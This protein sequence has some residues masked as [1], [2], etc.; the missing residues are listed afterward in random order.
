M[1]NVMDQILVNVMA[2]DRMHIKTTGVSVYAMKITTDMTALKLAI[3]ASTTKEH[4][5]WHVMVLV[6]ARSHMTV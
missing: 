6:M 5:M 3:L 2:V 4:A 1:V